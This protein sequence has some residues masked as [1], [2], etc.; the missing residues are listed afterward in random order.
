MVRR[1]LWAAS[2]VPA[3]SV[4]GLQLVGQRAGLALEQGGRRSGA[5]RALCLMGRWPENLF[6][7]MVFGLAGFRLACARRPAGA[8]VLSAP[9]SRTTPGHRVAVYP[10]RPGALMAGPA[11]GAP[12]DPSRR[13]AGRHHRQFG[14]GQTV[15]GPGLRVVAGR[16]RC[17]DPSC[18]L[19]AIV[20]SAL[21]GASRTTHPGS[22][23]QGPDRFSVSLRR[24]GGWRQAAWKMITSSILFM[25]MAVV[26]LGG[27]C[28]PPRLLVQVTGRRRFRGVDAG[29]LTWSIE[30]HRHG[31]K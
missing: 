4:L 16:G 25:C 20:M 9:G 6:T 18:Q 22:R 19:G 2:L 27:G 30:G 8:A 31:E 7:G 12:P 17:P 26:T 1:G 24:F 13:N 15:P 14:Q 28:P 5:R 11:G 21:T 3:V 10:A 29:D 23:A